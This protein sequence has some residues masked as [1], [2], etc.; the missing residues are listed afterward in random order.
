MLAGNIA[1]EL[2]GQ[3]CM[4][5][6]NGPEET[7]LCP[8]IL[9]LQFVLH[10]QVEEA[11][12][13]LFIW[14]QYRHAHVEVSHHAAIPEVPDS[15]QVLVLLQDDVE[16]GVQ[17]PERERVRIH[18]EDAAVSGQVPECQLAELVRKEAGVGGVRG[19]DGG[20]LAE[21]P[22]HGLEAL[23]HPL[24][25]GQVLPDKEQLVD[26]QGQVL[27]QRGAQRDR[28]LDV[29]FDVVLVSDDCCNG[30]RLLPCSCVRSLR[31][32]LASSCPI[33]GLGLGFLAHSGHQERG[34][35]R[36]A[37]RAHL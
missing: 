12:I 35:L 11:F 23:R 34:F 15:G 4:L 26:T 32:A 7:L 17:I 19:N 14:P 18:V 36:P 20:Y 29:L 1:I 10:E 25:Q 8:V 30:Q 37:G 13:L 22:A 9:I 27:Q 3:L 6:I 21:A 16:G 28:P 31:R 2:Q 5:W 24:G 33:C